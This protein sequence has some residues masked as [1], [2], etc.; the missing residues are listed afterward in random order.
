MSDNLGNRGK[1]IALW[2]QDT[3]TLRVA[4]RAEGFLDRV[5]VTCFLHLWFRRYSIW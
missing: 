4:E 1:Q 2:T 5:V 3:L